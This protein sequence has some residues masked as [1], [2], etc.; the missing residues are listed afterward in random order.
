MYFRG[1]NC[2]RARGMRNCQTVTSGLNYIS[3]SSSLCIHRERFSCGMRRIVVGITTRTCY[4]A[5]AVAAAPHVADRGSQK[6]G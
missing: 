3:T 1:A 6:R 4:I 5:D 2:S